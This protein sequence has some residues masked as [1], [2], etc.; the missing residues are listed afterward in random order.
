M[1]ARSY[2]HYL[3]RG[4]GPPLLLVHGLMVTGAMFDG[5]FDRFAATRRVVVPDLRGH[6]ESRRLPPP[7]AVRVVAED[8]ARLL[9]RLAIERADVLGYSQ[10]GA[11]A[12]QLAVDFPEHCERLVLA[13]TYAFN[14]MTLRERLEA[15]A[16]P[17]L[18][19]ALGM[20]GFSR[21]LFATG[22]DGV[23]HATRAR[24]AALV[25][26]QD[27]DR[28][29]GAWNEAMAFDGRPRLRSIRCP[30]LVVAGARDT[31]V[32]MHHAKMLYEGIPGARLVVVEG[33]GHG[34][35][36]THSDALVRATQAFLGEPRAED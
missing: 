8:L 3:E 29:I 24:L 35:I 13:C 31:A 33:A 11:V 18:L 27:R 1:S 4:E 2:V 14:A 15:R 23:D 12:Q 17:W 20:R 6:G 22:L 9:D 7:D 26:G 34:L 10:G 5:V 30:T 19:R 28:M 36:W 25:A 21:L 16:A 32:P